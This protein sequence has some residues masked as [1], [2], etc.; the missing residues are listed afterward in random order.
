MIIF[1]FLVKILQILQ[2]FQGQLNRNCNN[3]Q[4][5]YQKEAV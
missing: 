1:Y 2:I 5:N 4:I 3:G